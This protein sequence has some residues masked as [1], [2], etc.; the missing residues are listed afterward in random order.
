[1]CLNLLAMRPLS[2]MRCESADERIRTLPAR[3]ILYT[4]ADT[5][6][7]A[8][9]PINPHSKKPREGGTGVGIESTRGDGKA[10]DLRER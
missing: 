9:P 7:L 4:H 3:D 8:P 6:P 2:L 5:V 10:S 1:M